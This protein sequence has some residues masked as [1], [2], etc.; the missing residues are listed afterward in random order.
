MVRYSGVS[1]ALRWTHFFRLRENEMVPI[2]VGV[3]INEVITERLDDVFLDKIK[4][5][6]QQK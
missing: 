1:T 5:S 2:Q 4:L 6:E 3:K